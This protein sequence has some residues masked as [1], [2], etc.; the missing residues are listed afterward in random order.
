MTGSQEREGNPQGACTDRE[1]PATSPRAAE[2][3]ERAHQQAIPALERDRSGG[4][5]NG[6]QWV[7]REVSGMR[8]GD[9]DFGHALTLSQATS[10]G[11]SRLKRARTPATSDAAARRSQD[12]LR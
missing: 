9:R 7:S 12:L 2:T 4:D 1:R 6:R 10:S 8:Q 11:S 5:G 3:D